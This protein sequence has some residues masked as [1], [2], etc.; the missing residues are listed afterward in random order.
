[1]QAMKHVS[2]GS[3]LTLKLTSPDVENRN[4]NGPRKGQMSFKIYFEKGTMFSILLTEHYDNII[5]SLT[6]EH[7]EGNIVILL[8]KRNICLHIVDDLLSANTN[9]KLA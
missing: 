9:K 2:K 3:T 4:I 6:S 1:M 7:R 8:T 5:E